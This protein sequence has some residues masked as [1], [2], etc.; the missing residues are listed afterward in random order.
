MI[1]LVSTL[2]F[3]I[4]ATGWVLIVFGLF[5]LQFKFLILSLTAWATC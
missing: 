1:K 2:Q 3:K 5:L 4:L